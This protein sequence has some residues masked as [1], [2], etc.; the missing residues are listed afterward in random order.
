MFGWIPALSPLLLPILLLPI[1][2]LLSRPLPSFI[3]LW[4][5]LLFAFSLVLAVISVVGIAASAAVV[6]L[7]RIIFFA[8]VGE[9][10]PL[11]FL[12]LLLLPVV[13]PLLLLPGEIMAILFRGLLLLP[14]LLPVLL[15]LLLLVLLLLHFLI[16]SLLGLRVIHCCFFALFSPRSSFGRRIKQ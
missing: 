3:P 11:S 4:P 12:V 14:L 16:G 1:L 6:V 15:P 13:L 7:P 9:I 2:L 5:L 10:V 8:F